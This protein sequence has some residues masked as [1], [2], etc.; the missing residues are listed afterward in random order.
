MINQISIKNFKAFQEATIELSN[1]NLFT[2]I[3]GVGKSSFIQSLLLLRQ[4]HLDRQLP[5]QIVLNHDKYVR[6]GKSQDVFNMYAGEEDSLRITIIT[7]SI[8][9][10]DIEVCAFSD[11]TFL[12]VKSYSPN[13]WEVDNESLFNNNFQYLYAER[14]SPKKIFAVDQYIVEALRSLG[15]KGE[16]TAHFIAKYQADKVIL[17]SLIDD[18]AISDKLTAQIDVWLAKITKGV[19]LVPSLYEDLGVA[20]ISYQFGEDDLTPEF[21]PENVGFGLTYVLPIITALLAA[22]PNDLIII[23]NPES[24]LH[25]NGQAQIGI[26]L[27][28]AA[29]DG[30]QIILETHSDHVLNGI[31]VATK[32]YHQ[33]PENDRVGKGIDCNNVKIFFFERQT[34]QH[35]TQI[36]PIKVNNKGRL[37]AWPKSFFDEWSNM[38][39]ELLD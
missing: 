6:L 37:S 33:A 15:S 7:D 5:K 38:L 1:L 3:N 4:S 16:Y 36:V 30:V 27:A 35:T 2:G 23:E 19:R 18:N 9:K 22:K 10:I 20:R 24:H 8:E 12:E 26:M 28:L 13:N 11:K 17:P 29:Q 39:D 14:I 21:L 25:P 31:R 32:R 34:S